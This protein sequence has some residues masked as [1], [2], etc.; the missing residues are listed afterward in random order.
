[1]YYMYMDIISFF[2]QLFII[3]QLKEHSVFI[4]ICIQLH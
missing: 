1:M 2:F 3:V 4:E